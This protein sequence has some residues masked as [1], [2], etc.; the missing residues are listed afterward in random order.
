MKIGILTHHWVYN[1]GANLQT[2]ATQAALQAEGH[3]PVIINYREPR[4]VERYNDA[5][6]PEQAAM[7]HDFC[8]RY[9][10]QSQVL[11]NAGQVE[12]FCM[13]SL[14]AVVVGSD[15]V[16]ML[17]PQFDPLNIVRK[18]RNPHFTAT[19]KL[20]PYWLDWKE[21]ADSKKH[22]IKAS[23]A[24]SSMGTY[25]FCLPPGIIRS[26]RNSIKQFRYVSVRD[27]WTELMIKVITRGRT[28]PGICPDPVFS[29]NRNFSIPENE[30]PAADVSKT[31]LLSGNYRSSWIKAFAEKA[32]DMGYSVAGIPN[33]DSSYDYPEVDFHI[34][35]PL[36][37]LQWFK[38]FAGA[39]GFVG[40]RFHA[41]VSCIANKT[42]VINVDPHGK[43][44]LI[45]LSSKMH[46]LCQR[47]GIQNRYYTLKKIQ[48]TNPEDILQTLFDHESRKK[49]DEYA[50]N[51]EKQF[52]DVI[53]TI[54][55]L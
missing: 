18:I 17:I 50:E 27:R 23:I 28:K 40:V 26:I 16:F 36:S 33:P 22:M 45:K 42:P 1:F 31:I 14:D 37:P 9:L 11:H 49:A 15:A 29:L 48:G 12:E 32:H 30:D 41:L 47:A 38:L 51:A 54:S 4:K 55:A 46:D 34:K 53:R 19:K 20:P 39:A 43:S 21:S 5:V 13:D 3:D 7:H 44:R 35:L 6:S 10:H 25:F 2:L 8:K 52:T 24:A